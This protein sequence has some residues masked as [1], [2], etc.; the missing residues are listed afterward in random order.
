M[1]SRQPFILTWPNRVR[2]FRGKNIFSFF[3]DMEYHHRP[4]LSYLCCRNDKGVLHYSFQER[5]QRSKSHCY[6]T[7]NPCYSAS[8]C[9]SSDTF[10]HG[11]NGFFL[12]IYHIIRLFEFTDTFFIVSSF[13]SSFLSFTGIR[14][15]YVNNLFS[16]FIGIIMHSH[17]S[18]HGIWNE[19][20][21]WEE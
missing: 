8:M 15:F 10:F 7:I 3:T 12:W 19:V 21:E 4:S 6:F 5:N 9:S 14:R 16:L 2:M 17:Y 13:H 18:L 11:S 20:R 1:T